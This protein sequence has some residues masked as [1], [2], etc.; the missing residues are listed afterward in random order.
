MGVKRPLSRRDFLK[1]VAFGGAAVALAAC[2]TSPAAPAA[3]TENEA[4]AGAT[5]AP[6]A[7]V[8]SAAAPPSGEVIQLDIWTGWTEAAAKNIEAILDGYNKSQD[9][10]VAKHVVVPEAMDQKLLAA[11]AS[12]TPPGG[13]IVFG[14]NT[15]YQLA[16]QD[17]VLP[18]D[19]VGDPN[20]VGALK[21]WMAPALWDLGVYNG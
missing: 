18:L 4:A 13:A 2:G 14:A 3:T 19:G 11:I 17:A 10:I 15:A 21:N 20:Q 9:R 7:D 5:T 1:R 12:G 8:T 6:A 16:A